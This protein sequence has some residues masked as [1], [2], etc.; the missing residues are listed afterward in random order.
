MATQRS[1][2]ETLS[3]TDDDGVVL[4]GTPIS[5][6]VQT[7][8]LV[9]EE[10]NIAYRL[11]VE[12]HDCPAALQS[13]DHRH[14]HPFG[15]IPAL[16]HRGKRLYETSALCRYLD[17]TFPKTTLVPS[18][19]WEAATMEQ[20]IS[21]LCSYMHGPC[22]SQLVGQYVFPR[23][24]ADLPD[25]TVIDAAQAPVRLALG[26]LERAT[27]GRLVLAGEALSLADLFVVPLLLQLQLTPEGSAWLEDYPAVRAYLQ[28]M[29]RRVS[30]VRAMQWLQEYL[31]AGH[32]LQC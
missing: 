2:T 3:S 8:I 16:E 19:P 23:G 10:K 7:V 4:I 15:K 31:P 26:E 21:N 6:F 12:G 29:Q 9:C 5:H 11:V 27:A 18:H 28:R 1:A 13:A 20:W 25:Q 22:I 17:L 24:P 30:V 32:R 14:Y